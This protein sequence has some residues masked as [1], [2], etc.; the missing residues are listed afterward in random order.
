MRGAVST[1]ESGESPSTSRRAARLGGAVGA[2]VALTWVGGHVGFL[3][4]F[5]LLA[6]LLATTPRY[7]FAVGQ[8]ALVAATGGGVPPGSLVLAE[9]LLLW[10]LLTPDAGRAFEPRHAVVTVAAT[11][12]LC[13]IA[14]A[15]LA[16]WRAAWI[17]GV[18]VL[19]VAGLAAY[20][21]HRYELV[22]LGNVPASGEGAVSSDGGV[23]P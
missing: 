15:S 5:A 7:A 8:F 23:D 11:G 17:A 21:V 2:A 1:T 22:A 4:G 19:A 9:A 14:W 20:G 18:V 16:A 10:V 6:A 12:G 3:G 13:A